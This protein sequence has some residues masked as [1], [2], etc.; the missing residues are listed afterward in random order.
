MRYITLILLFLITSNSLSQEKVS[1]GIFQDAK[2]M[3]LGDHR[4]NGPGTMDVILRFKIEGKQNKIGYFVYFFNYEH[5]NLASTFNRYSLSAGYTF[6]TINLRNNFLNRFEF[7]PIVGYGILH[8]DRSNSL[9]RYYNWSFG[10]ETAFRVSPFMKISFLTQLMQRSDLKRKKTNNRRVA[11][12][13]WFIG[14]V[15][16]LVNLGAEKSSYYF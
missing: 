11:R 5:A 7:T 10:E 16:N 12:F 2:L 4:G 6:N 13:S 14:T 1:L 9:D 8:R 15:F 3:F